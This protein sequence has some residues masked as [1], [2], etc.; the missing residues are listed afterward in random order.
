MGNFK[1]WDSNTKF[2]RGGCKQSSRLRETCSRYRKFKDVDK[3]SGIGNE[4]HKRLEE[5]G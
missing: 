4:L 5:C 3:I 1:I 2:E